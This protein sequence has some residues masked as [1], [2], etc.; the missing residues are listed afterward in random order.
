MWRK[1]LI[2]YHLIKLANKWIA[3]HKLRYL[4]SWIS[5]ALVSIILV[6]IYSVGF[7]IQSN[8]TD[9]LK[10]NP[11]NYQIHM[12][13]MKET[14]TKEGVI[15]DLSIKRAEEIQKEIGAS[16]M[17]IIFNSSLYLENIDDALV[18]IS[19]GKTSFVD[20][21]HSLLLDKDIEYL[22]LLYS[23]NSDFGFSGR[24]F[25]KSTT[26]KAVVTSA[27]LESYGFSADDAL[28]KKLTFTD[29]HAQKYEY[30]I[31]G[32]LTDVEQN[33]M[34]VGSYIYL[35]YVDGTEEKILSNIDLAFVTYDFDVETNMENAMAK[36]A[37]YEYV[38]DQYVDDA[39][40]IISLSKA[41]EFTGALIGV[42]LLS[43]SSIGLANSVLVTINE[44]APFMNFFRIIG[45]TRKNYY[46]IVAYTATLQGIIGGIIGCILSF[47]FQSQIYAV[48]KFMDFGVG[49]FI[50]TFKIEPMACIYAMCFCIIISLLTSIISFVGIRRNAMLNGIYSEL[51]FKR[52]N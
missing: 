19:K 18:N 38:F 26:D 33:P 12:R 14:L 34:L 52:G 22:G 47:L 40:D 25:D 4:L 23:R 24:L 45:L 8:I 11:L 21:N 36:M 49:T 44:N 28:G 27:F 30:Q 17:R 1:T 31:L 13:N 16:D 5:F 43:I 3:R 32:V 10:V 46:F 6:A 29:E 50:H 7:S 37:T 35:P 51:I 9:Q 20:I 15:R 48:I 42:I 41:F 2:K 39:E